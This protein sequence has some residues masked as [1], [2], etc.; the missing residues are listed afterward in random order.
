MN[1]MR[2]WVRVAAAVMLTAVA[3][4]SGCSSKPKYDTNLLKNAS[5]E[6]FGKDGVPDD[7]KLELFRGDPND[8]VVRYGVD[9]LAQDGKHSFYFQADPGTRRFYFLQQD[10]TVVGAEPVRV[11][12]WI[13]GDD[14]EM[15]PSQYAM[16]NLLLTFYDKDHHRF[17][18]ERAADRRTPLRPGTY[19]W[20]EQSYTFPVP[21]GT[22]YIA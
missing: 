11:K 14:V 17:Q 7:W 15:Q 5:F 1:R 18:V 8:P 4:Y 20:E 10:V 6:K 22:H 2:N 19:P 9:T 13:A 21:D 12:G 16:C 3:V